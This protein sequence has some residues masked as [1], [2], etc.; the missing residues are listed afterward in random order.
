MHE[1]PLSF[2]EYVDVRSLLSYL[3][4]EVTMISK[5]T[6]K[7]DLFKMYK[8]ENARMKYILEEIVRM[9]CL[10]RDLWTSLVADGYLA[11][12]V[13]FIDKE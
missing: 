8:R 4:P 9:I 3:H 12:T 10:T 5:N 7:S 6:T 13:H 1:S 2:V 11:I